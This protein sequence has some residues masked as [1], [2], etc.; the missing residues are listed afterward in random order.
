MFVSKSLSL[1]F[2]VGGFFG[3]GFEEVRLW[4]ILEVELVGFVGMRRDV[5]L[6]GFEFWV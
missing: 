4:Y 1:V 5:C 2:R 3:L 6:L